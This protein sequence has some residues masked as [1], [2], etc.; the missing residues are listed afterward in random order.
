MTYIPHWSPGKFS[1]ATYAPFKGKGVR[2]GNFLEMHKNLWSLCVLWS[3]AKTSCAGSKFCMC[4]IDYTCTCTGEPPSMA[5]N[6]QWPPLCNSQV[7][8]FPQGVLPQILDKG[9]FPI[10][11]KPGAGAASINMNAS[12]KSS[13]SFGSRSI[14]TTGGGSRSNLFN[15]SS[16]KSVAIDSS[17]AD[18]AQTKPPVQVRCS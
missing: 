4:A 7:P 8:L 14:R 12:R 15:S 1:L 17:R 10:S 3:T 5:T 11:R 6:L 16:R 2:Y 13:H 18:K 9:V